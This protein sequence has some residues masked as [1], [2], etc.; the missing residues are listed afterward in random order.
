[1][2]SATADV[3]PQQKPARRLDHPLVIVGASNLGSRWALFPRATRGGGKG[4][5]ARAVR[6]L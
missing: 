1:M 4:S 6:A 3:T 2:A 5:G